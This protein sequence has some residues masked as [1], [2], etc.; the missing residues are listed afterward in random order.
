MLVNRKIWL[1]LTLLASVGS[2]QVACTTWDGSA[3]SAG[4]EGGEGGEGG[5]AGE[6]GTA[7][8]FPGGSFATALE[9]VFDGEGGEGG[10]G[11]VKGKSSVTV[12]ALNDSQITRLVAGNTLRSEYHFAAYFEQG[13]SIEGWSTKWTE[14]PASDCKPADLDDGKCW[15]S[16]TKQLP[17]AKWTVRNGTLCTEPAVPSL[18]GDGSCASV[19]LV[20]D[21]VVLYDKDNKIVGKGNDAYEGREIGETA[22]R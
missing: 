21:R 16:V 18:T 11:L 14:H 17:A 12:P 22:R 10:L 5:E 1:G 3:T 2:A 7:K 15:K 20:L 13:G 9:K 8:D 4:T 19:F 6:A